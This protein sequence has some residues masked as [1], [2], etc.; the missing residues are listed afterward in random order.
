MDKNIREI[1]NP[2]ELRKYKDEKTLYTK[3][4]HKKDKEILDKLILIEEQAFGD[5]G[6]DEWVMVPFIRHGRIIALYY[7][8]EII[9]GAQ[10]LKDWDH[11]ENAYLY[12]IGIEKKYRGQG[13]GTWFLKSCIEELKKEGIKN[14]E[15]TVDPRNSVAIKVYQEKLGFKITDERKHEYG[16][17]EHR[18]V[19]ELDLYK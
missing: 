4:I 2:E 6:L 19:M 9:G 16:S 13:Y 10:F 1:T 3:I 17:G 5:A 14:I 15:L 7:G 12:G 8:D 11:T 18:T